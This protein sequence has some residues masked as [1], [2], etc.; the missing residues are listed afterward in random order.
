ML[1]ELT[2]GERAQALDKAMR[3]RR[4]RA[5]LKRSLKMGWIKPEEAL[6][7]PCAER[8]RVRD[9]LRALPGIGAPTAEKIMHRVGISDRTRIAGLGNRQRRRLMEALNEY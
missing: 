9:F 5:D 1:P 7:A 8:L 4:E 3:L 6:G 2:E